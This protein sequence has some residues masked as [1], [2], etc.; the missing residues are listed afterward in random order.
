MFL[1]KHINYLLLHTQEINGIE[2]TTTDFS[3]T[4]KSFKYAPSDTSYFLHVIPALFKLNPRLVIHEFSIGIASLIPTYFVARLIGAK[5]ILWGHGYDRKTG[6]Y[7]AR[8]IKD[9][10][11]LLLM[12][13]ADALI[14]Y[15]QEGKRNLSRYTAE[16]KMF[17][18]PNSL[19]TIYLSEIRQQLEQEDLA[20]MKHRIGFTAKYNLIFIGRLIKEKNPALLIESLSILQDQ[21]KSSVALHFVGGGPELINLRKLASNL[22]LN[23]L[24]F[25]HGAIHDDWHTGEMLFCSDLMIMP[26]YVGLSVN[27]ALNF[28]CPVITFKQLD[29]GPFHSP[30]IEYVIDQKTGFIL[31]EH[32]ARAI[33]RSVKNYLGN[34]AQ[35]KS[36]HA[37]IRKM[38]SETCSAEK[39]VDGF[40]EAIH[41]CLNQH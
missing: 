17:V 8:S 33:A 26:G 3:R 36:M 24:V 41:F 6:F 29:N 4:V 35:R 2:Q 39:F 37:E 32:T 30:E 22:E 25:F 19:N 9:R 38:V 34:E 10:L 12:R 16:H 15:S 21:F 14:L 18:A 28:D 23:H 20:Q 5:F 27:H 1:H 11:R 31:Q 7:P 40:K 13:R